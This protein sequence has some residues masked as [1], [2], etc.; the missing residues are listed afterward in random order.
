[1]DDVHN[2]GQPRVLLTVE[3]AAERLG[4]GRTTVYQLIANGD[5]GSVRIGRLRRIPADA[6]DAYVKH[7]MQQ[8]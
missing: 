5:L 6:I 7:L 3:Q 4:L 2:T 1:M 8:Q